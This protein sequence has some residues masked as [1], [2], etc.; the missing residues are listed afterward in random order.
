MSLMS[1]IAKEE[2]K[3]TY[4]RITNDEE[5]FAKFLNFVS[6]GNVYEYT[7]VE[8][9]YLYSQKPNS[10]VFYE[11]DNWKEI[12]RLPFRNSAV[13]INTQKMKYVFALESTYGRAFNGVWLLNN[14]QDIENILNAKMFGQSENDNFQ[15]HIKK[16]TQTYVRDILKVDNKN[17]IELIQNCIYC[18]IFTRITS[19][20]YDK[21]V[22][23]HIKK[24]YA[25]L[26]ISERY[27]F[28]N[29]YMVYIQKFSN[30]VLGKIQKTLKE[31]ENYEGRQNVSSE[32]NKINSERFTY[33]SNEQRTS[34]EGIRNRERERNRD[35]QNHSSNRQIWRNDIRLS[36]RKTARKI[37]INDNARRDSTINPGKRVSDDG[38]NGEHR[39]QVYRKEN[40]SQDVILGNGSIKNTSTHD[41]RRNSDKSDIVTTNLTNLEYEQL[42][43][44]EDENE[45]DD[46][47]ITIYD[48]K[49]TYL[50]PKLNDTVPEKYILAILK[51]GSSFE[52]GKRRISEI[53]KNNNLKAERI[54]LI[55]REYGIG[56]VSGEDLLHI[57][58]LVGY[59]YDNQGIKVNWCDN[60]IYN[61][62]NITWSTVDNYIEKLIQNKEYLD[63]KEI[64]VANIINYND[65]DYMVC[66][67]EDDNIK[68]TPLDKGDIVKL[69]KNEFIDKKVQIAK[70]NYIPTDFKFYDGWQPSVGSDK[71]RFNKNIEAIKVLKNIK[72]EERYAT[73]EEQDIL[74]HYVGWGGLSD[75]F[76]E[77]KYQDENQQL[78][79]LL[80]DS[81]YMSARKSVTDAF[82]TP[83]E[84]IDFIYKALDRMGFKG[85]NI[86]DPSCGIGN[87]ESGMPQKIFENS[88]IYTVEIDDISA[89]I[90]KSLHPSINI[91]H[92]GFEDLK[93]EDDNFYDLV[94]GNI[95]FG[96][97]SIYD[98]KYNKENLLI[99]DY[100]FEKSIDKLA[101]G[102]LLCF[103]TSAGTLDKEN[104]KV[105][106]YLAERADLI[107]AVRL[108]NNTF[109]SSANTKVTTDILFLQKRKN[110]NLKK[111]KWIDTALNQDSIRVNQYFID[112]PDKILG[113]LKTSSRYGKDISYVEPTI[114]LKNLL[115]DILDSIPKDIFS[116]YTN[117]SIDTI[118]PTID[119]SIKNNT[120]AMVNDYLF[121]RFNSKMIKLDLK[122]DKT[123]ERIKGLC[124]IR[125]V[126]KNLIDAELKNLPDVEISNLRKELND[127]Y[128]S[129]VKKNGYITNNANKQAFYKDVE[130]PLLCSLEKTEKNK[131]KKAPIFFERTILP[132]IKPQRVDTALEALNCSLN[133]FNRVDLK[134]IMNLTNKTFEEIKNDLKGEI[135]LNP[136]KATDDIYSGWES[137]EEYLSG[138]VRNKLF[139]AELKAEQEPEYLIN[140]E[141]LKQV[142]PTDLT[143]SEINVNLGVT[144]IDLE[145]YSDYMKSLFGFNYTQANACTITY[146]SYTNSYYIKNKSFAENNYEVN[147][148]YGT[149]RLRG[150]EIYERILNSSDVRVSD[151]VELPDNRYKYEVNHKETMLAR[152]KA[153]IIK[154]NFKSW[155]FSDTTRRQKYVKRYNELFNS[156]RLRTYDG[157]SLTFPGMNKNVNLRPHQKNAV[158]RVIRGNC[159]LLAH[160]VGA[161]KTYE[162]AASCMELKRLGLAN[163]PLITVPNHLIGQFAAEF[164]ELYPAA[165]L[166][167]ASE[168]DFLKDNRQKFTTKIATGKFDAII[169]GHSQFEKIAISNERQERY[170]KNEIEDISIGIKELLENNGEK[171][172][173]KQ[174]EASK[175]RMEVKLEKLKREEYKDDVL[176]F[177]ELGIDALFVDEAHN[178]KNLSFNTRMSRVAGINPQGSFKASD[179]AMKV[180]YIQEITG[181]KNVIFATGTPISNSMAEMYIMQKYLT[182][183]RLKQLGI[184][185]FDSWAATFGEVTTSLEL[186]PEGTGYREKTRFA[187]FINTPELISLFR[188]FADVQ[189][190]E[191]IQLDIPKLKNGNYTIV[192][193]EPGEFIKKIMRTFVE[194][195]ENIHSGSVEPHVDNMLKVC[196]DAKLLS[197]DVRMYDE[198]AV[199]E[200][201]CKL[202]KCVQNVIDVYKEHQDIKGTQIIF[203]D[204]GTPKKDKFNV[205]NYLKEELVNKGIPEN[206]ICFIHDAQND[207]DRMNMFA[208]LR[209]G[210]KRIII[211][212]TSK[213]GTGTNI[214][215]RIVAIHEIDCSWRPSDVEQ[216]EGRG[217][218][219]GNIN[220]E[221]EIFRYVTKGTFDAYN[222]NILVNKQHF[223]SQIM[224]GKIVEREND[225]IDKNELSYNEI[226]AIASG[227]PLIKE[228]NEVDN[229]VR[230]LSLLEKSY[231]DNLYELDNKINIEYPHKIK[232]NSLIKDNLIKDISLRDN[233]LRD[234]FQDENNN[235]KYKF[236]N[237]VFNSRKQISEYIYRSFQGV[238]SNATK[239]IGSM[240]A[241]EI[242]AHIDVLNEKYVL[243]RGNNEYS[244]LCSN[245]EN[246]NMIKLKNLLKSMDERLQEVDTKISKYQND[247]ESF[248]QECK[249]PF[250]H[251]ERLNELRTRQRELNNLLTE[252]KSNNHDNIV[253]SDMNLRKS[254]RKKL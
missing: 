189:T 97:F 64:E 191:T 152:E 201:D 12:G 212:S 90:S 112:N 138:D 87:F 151:R 246:G 233:V 28:L 252:S 100:F 11:Y 231:K 46:K 63:D 10:Q 195:A 37:R 4:K 137:A 76:N 8:E 93:G 217:L 5:E 125:F 81:E 235:T 26:S 141:K 230:K 234:F 68:M 245:A 216:K 29:N 32:R 223:I 33:S 71:D 207:K 192:E 70:E 180:A 15:N 183:N 104:T 103:I 161:G 242:L 78:K 150:L 96:N 190:S 16:L 102:G 27:Y 220:D 250:L 177:E 236:A 170:I 244:F 232:K 147:N 61:T 136:E 122:S 77:S 154:A 67:V 213:M 166:L 144:W 73:P 148:K 254:Q 116:S 174:L 186:A 165:E 120:Y 38:I 249:K 128:N 66:E 171:W 168:K 18:I 221:V 239:S 135:F 205:Y 178:Y 188:E 229:E 214:Q 45:E 208:D 127:S 111:E 118:I 142:V 155:L 222:W 119:Y 25:N 197:T 130:Y 22:L 113:I 123:I 84:I 153:E 35:G 203:S 241:F 132:N 149:S 206:E 218:R 7:F 30:N 143:A 2:A 57:P 173:I 58:N 228:K 211:G 224:S 13:Y 48:N 21:N 157:S 108:P 172:S 159:T 215:E 226:M 88:E 117:Y 79:N 86:L 23:E 3:R 179:M 59:E 247:I 47:D 31:I 200:I 219:Q 89:D 237:N 14:N 36:E 156:V 43:L 248:K 114:S 238:S 204:I 139:L 126:L 17:C 145:D 62:G 253:E 83:P 9:L 101:P 6:R 158:A 98:V 251:Q 193:S 162:I 50:N 53:Y 196:H 164:Q 185:H 69:N 24:E 80:T 109:L 41:S 1:E 51:A 20:L 225:D 176:S 121:Y 56:G 163:K 169:M 198:N 202:N 94:I 52:G 34:N 40:A 107:A 175:K 194:R 184:Y 131:I 181:G 146:N 82:Y 49:Y 44:F 115:N 187:K 42:N 210:Q 39:E 99:H 227:N 182:P 19:E 92:C 243:V 54:K 106:E 167:V 133:E 199:P 91:R 240:G 60:E 124:D 134:Y 95:P 74:S 55:K 160:C 105:R 85:G 209:C 129:F 65:N 110:L 75:F 140:V 72:N